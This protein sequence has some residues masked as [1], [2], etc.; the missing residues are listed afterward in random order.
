MIQCVFSISNFSNPL[1]EG[2]ENHTVNAQKLILKY[3]N[4]SKQI[5]CKLR[6]SPKPQT[7]SFK[8]TPWQNPPPHLRAAPAV[9]PGQP[10]LDPR[11][12]YVAGFKPTS[13]QP[14]RALQANSS[15]LTPNQTAARW[16]RCRPSLKNARPQAAKEQ[17]KNWIYPETC[18]ILRTWNILV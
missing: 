14:C 4:K 11:A 15:S 6:N 13:L 12:R 10:V 7:L 9:Q 16:Q 8:I 17:L 3:V 2:I 18:E 1:W 5:Q